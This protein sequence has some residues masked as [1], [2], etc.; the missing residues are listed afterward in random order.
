LWFTYELQR[1]LSGTPINAYAVCPGFVSTTAAPST[2]GPMRLLMSLVMPRMPFATSVDDA[3]DSFVFMALD[4]SL[5]GVGG[6]FYG[7]RHPIES[8]PQSRD[9]RQAQRFW[10]L[11][12]RLHA[13]HV[14]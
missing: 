12:G 3:T 2:T 9:P 14:R 11:V 10:Q 4:P 13:D 7:E 6:A 5:D 1:R 8:S